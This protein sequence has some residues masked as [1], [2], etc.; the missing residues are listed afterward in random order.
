MLDVLESDMDDAGL[1]M[2]TLTSSLSKLLKTNNGCQIWTIVILI[3]IL[4]I[5]IALIIWT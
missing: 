5:L 4:I 3:L 2:N 1:N